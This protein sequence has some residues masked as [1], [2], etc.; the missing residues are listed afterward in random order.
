MAKAYIFIET[1]IG[2]AFEVSKALTNIPKVIYADTVTGHFD[3]VVVV[4]S[5][6]LYE[7]KDTIAKYVHPIDGI[8]KTVTCVSIE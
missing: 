7:V 2:K 4:E 6:N 1:S 8:I 5:N 3:V